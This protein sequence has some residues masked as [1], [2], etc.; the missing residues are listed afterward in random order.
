[1]EENI[2]VSVIIPIYGVEAFIG[3]FAESLLNQSFKDLEFIFVN[4][5]TK[6]NSME[7]LQAVIDKHEEQKEKV[8]IIHHS[9]NKGLPAARNTGMAIAKGEYIYHCDSDDYLEPT[10]IEDLY[11]TAIEKEAD[12]VWCDWLLSYCNSERVMNQPSFNS[13]E[14]ALY[15][16]LSDKMKYNVWNKLV[17][18]TLYRNNCILFPEGHSMGEDMTMIMLASCSN[19]VAHI[20]KPLYHYIKTN[21]TAMTMNYS[22]KALDD[23]KF[24]V[25]RTIDFLNKKPTTKQKIETAKNLFKLNVKLPFLISKDFTQYEL[26]NNWFPESN[27]YIW[28]NDNLPIRTKILQWMA[29]KKQWW[30]VR[31]YFILIY[32]LIYNHFYK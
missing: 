20:A 14:E 28:Q 27:S 16:L 7:V 5:C 32:Q 2:K 21:S 19:R 22:Q 15:G 31:I 29:S 3:R 25:D 6:D 8:Q 30:Y 10:L 17:K 23:L 26:W 13:S 18:T 24:N 11:R 9:H 4:D 12:Y 1:M